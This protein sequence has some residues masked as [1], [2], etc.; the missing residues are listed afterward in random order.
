MDGCWNLFDEA[1]NAPHGGCAFTLA[2][3]RR[4]LLDVPVPKPSR[5]KRRQ[6]EPA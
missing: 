1:G 2:E 6:P 3:A 4:L 5:S